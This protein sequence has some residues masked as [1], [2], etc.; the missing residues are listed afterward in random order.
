[1]END[2]S[3]G[4][5]ELYQEW[6]LTG[7]GK[8]QFLWPVPAHHKPDVYI[9]V[10]Y[11][12]AGQVSEIREWGEGVK[13]PLVR[14]PTIENGRL[15]RSEYHDPAESRHGI[16]NYE[17]TPQGILKGRYETDPK[18]KLRFR[19][20]ITCDAQ[21]RF[22]EEKL[23]DHR[24]RLTSRHT[25]EYGPGHNRMIKESVFGGKD[26]QSLEGFFQRQYDGKQRMTRQ[27]W[28]GPDG[29]ELR[30]FSYTYDENDYQASIAIM[31]N[32]VQTVCSRFERDE[33][34]S[35]KEV[36]FVGE[37]E[38]ELN[39]EQLGPEGALT[40]ASAVERPLGDLTDEDQ[41]LLMGEKGL[42]EAMQ[43]SP[44]QIKALSIVAY[45]HFENSQF[46]EAFKLYEMLSMLEPENI[47]YKN[48]AGAAA[49][50]QGHA[51]L[52]LNWYERALGLDPKHIASLVGKG[53]SLLHLQDVDES[54]KTFEKVFQSSP[55]P[56]DPT[57][58]RAQSIVM[59][60][61]N[62]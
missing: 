47:Y 28:H 45:S 55:D 3:N 61:M 37:N 13:E 18:G 30:A 25:Y 6:E 42:A 34:G 23:L 15:V 43:M 16:N 21:G 27:S 14:K 48:G 11:N 39:R 57:V 36:V 17:Y 9:E 60:I 4:K 58:L 38:E 26:G 20:E 31:E 49:L 1:M 40:K 53:E 44:K 52:A 7:R 10:H 22:V 32:G 50:Q 51:Q 33:L 56:K 54:L 5:K 29:K 8:Y 12:A 59:A 19:I 62:A 2:M 46:K 24:K 35:K 41:A